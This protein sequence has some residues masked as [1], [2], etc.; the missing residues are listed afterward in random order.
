MAADSLNTLF[1]CW[2]IFDLT[3]MQ[4]GN[5][6]AFAVS[7]WSK[8]LV[9]FDLLM[10]STTPWFLIISTALGADPAMGGIIAFYCQAFFAWRLK[11]LTG[12]YWIA[13]AV[14]FFGFCVMSKCLPLLLPFRNWLKWTSSR[15]IG[16]CYCTWYPAWAQ[17]DCV[18]GACCLRVACTRCCC[19]ALWASR[20]SFLF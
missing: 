10:C 2:W 20:W 8:S 4:F 13:G 11:V 6:A 9:T 3:I 18:V 12:N 5:L 7:N 19:C 17:W 1:S 16:D 15:G 14:F